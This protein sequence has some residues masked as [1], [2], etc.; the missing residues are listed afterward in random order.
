[1]FESIDV[2]VVELR[3]KVR[4]CEF[5]LLFDSLVRDRIVGGIRSDSLRGRLFRELGFI[6]KFVIDMCRVA[7]VSVEE[8]RSLK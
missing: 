2:Y 8:F 1:M 4:Y 6:L 7:E 3:N 5:G